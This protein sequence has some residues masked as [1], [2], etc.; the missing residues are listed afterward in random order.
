M[1]RDSL[2]TAMLTLCLQ[3]S[4]FSVGAMC[5]CEKAAAKVKGPGDIHQMQRSSCLHSVY[6]GGFQ[7]K[8]LSRDHVQVKYTGAAASDE[9]PQSLTCY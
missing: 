6:E 3:N 1:Q 4:S 2:F 5:A 9:K 8:T 7:L